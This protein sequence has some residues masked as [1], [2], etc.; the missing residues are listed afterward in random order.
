MHLGLP[1][2]GA[3]NVVHVRAI[4]GGTSER[5]CGHELLCRQPVSIPSHI[6]GDVNVIHKLDCMPLAYWAIPAVKN[7]V[8]INQQHAL[9]KLI[10]ATHMHLTTSTGSHLALRLGWKKKKKKKK[11]F[12]K[13]LRLGKK[14]KTLDN[15]HTRALLWFLSTFIHS[16]IHYFILFSFHLGCNFETAWLILVLILHVSLICEKTSQRRA[17][18]RSCMSPT[19]PYKVKCWNFWLKDIHACSS[20]LDSCMLSCSGPGWKFKIPLLSCCCSIVSV[21]W[22][23]ES[24]ESSSSA[25][26]TEWNQLAAEMNNMQILKIQT[27]QYHLDWFRSGFF[28]SSCSSVSRFACYKKFACMLYTDPCS[29][30]KFSKLYGFNSHGFVSFAFGKQSRPYCEMTAGIAWHRCTYVWFFCF[31]FRVDEITCCGVKWTE[32]DRLQQNDGIARRRYLHPCIAS[33]CRSVFLHNRWAACNE[34]GV[35]VRSPACK[36]WQRI[37]ITQHPRRMQDIPPVSVAGTPT[38]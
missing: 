32:Q 17:K 22:S 28:A 34:I 29:G 21:C 7:N 37:K 11:N 6:Q 33:E 19:A 4:G 13:H 16:I 14:G 18:I 5:S 2:Q 31:A 23:L 10:L 36:T 8:E 12:R 9:R 24:R 15:R 38:Q 30:K 27:F 1:S 25:K 35:A 3:N 26:D 20:R